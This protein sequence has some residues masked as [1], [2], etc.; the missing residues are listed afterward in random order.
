[1]AGWS[2]RSSSFILIECLDARYE[3]RGGL[4]AS[5]KNCAVLDTLEKS[6]SRSFYMCCPVYRLGLT[7]GSISVIHTSPY[8]RLFL[9]TFKLCF[10]L[11]RHCV[12]II[13]AFW[14]YEELT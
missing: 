14:F 3:N 1:M 5:Y 13:A 11:S 4:G 8:W 7:F 12:I 2:W 9:K 10:L 6:P